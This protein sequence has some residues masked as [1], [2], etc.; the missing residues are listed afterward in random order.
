M[1]LCERINEDEIVS[2]DYITEL[3]TQI[4]TSEVPAPRLGVLQAVLEALSGR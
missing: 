4:T 3:C 1:C 2:Y